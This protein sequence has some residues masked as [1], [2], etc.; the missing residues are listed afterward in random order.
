MLPFLLVGPWQGH[1]TDTQPACE[2]R[3][4]AFY[5]SPRFPILFCLYITLLFLKGPSH[6]SRT[7]EGKSTLSVSGA[8]TAGQT[9][10]R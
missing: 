10:C 6:A 1:Q 9:H 4:L 3:I 5:W 8:G 2:K 7:R